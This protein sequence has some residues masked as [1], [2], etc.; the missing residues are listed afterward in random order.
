MTDAKKKKMIITINGQ[1]FRY[2]YHIIFFHSAEIRLSVNS[3]IED[4]IVYDDVNI[5]TVIMYYKG[6]ILY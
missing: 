3:A 2:C 6:T 1:T 5:K 4:D